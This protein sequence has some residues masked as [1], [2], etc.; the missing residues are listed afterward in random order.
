MKKKQKKNKKKRNHLPFRLNV[1]FFIVFLL[2][3]TLILKLGLTQ[4]V[5]GEDYKRE[6]EKKEEVTVS[7]SVPRGKIYDRNGNVIV[8]NIP[9]N[10][11]TYTGFQGTTADER[12]E[13]ARDL[14]IFIDKDT[15]SVTER[16]KKDFW[17]LTHPEE[18]LEKITKEELNKEDDG[19]L[20]AKDIY[21]LQLDRITEE[22]LATITG[23]ELEVLAIYREFSGYA[24][25]P[26]IVKSR[27]ENEND[28][29]TEEEYA[30]VS[31][32]LAQLPGV[33]TT[34]DWLR[35]YP[36]GDT[37][38]TVLGNITSSKEGLPSEVEDYYVAKEYSRNDRV[39]KS[40][41]EK[42]YE[43]V[44]HGQKEKVKNITD[45]AGNPLDQEVITEGE[46]GKDLVLS[47]DMD[48]QIA[49]EKII[50]EEL[51]NAKSKP[52][53]AF[54]DRAFVV[55]M[56]PSTGEVLSLAGK[57]YTTNEQG[58]VELWDY[59][60]GTFQEAFE[61][62]STVKG[63]TLLTGYETGVVNPG[64]S[65]LDEV[66]YIKGSPQKKSWE[67]MGRIND[68]YALKRSSN[69]YMFKIAISLL[70]GEYQ[71]NQPIPSN[72]EAFDLFRYYFNQFGLGI[73]TGID[74]PGEGTGYVGQDTTSGLLLD[75][76]IGQYDT[77]TPLQLT[78]YVSTIANGGYRIKPQV[79]KD[80]HEPSPDQ[81]GLG[82]VLKE[83]EP[84]V[85]NKIDMKTEYIEQ[86][87]EGFRQVMQ[88]TG[89]TAFGHFGASTYKPAGKTGTAEVYPDGE[90]L[91]YNLTL[92]GYAPY[93]NPEV[94]FAVVVPNADTTG[95]SQINK[96]IGKRILDT[97]FDLKQ[98]R[99][100]GT[101][102]QS[103]EEAT[104]TES[105]VIDTTTE[106]ENEIENENE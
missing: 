78:Q 82:P 66:L 9:L 33:D 24:L 1:L 17:L 70:G 52:G 31:E 91:A 20:E 21:K 25:T 28:E 34:T 64:E 2:F 23:Q 46:N 48:L 27:S 49:V 65:K 53:S 59:A 30:V 36:Y 98:Q 100:S 73:K 56:N 22:E 41:I 7:A 61:M 103:T 62:G 43:E 87:Q 76:A 16:D 74:L 104:N 75:M 97:Y 83:F 10:A 99:A 63:A 37:F 42:Q 81:E 11:I 89:G 77:Y 35:E 3:S 44:L 5:Y 80:I 95:K 57:Q 45:K 92:I 106:A 84:L 6:I 71:R 50:E 90:T 54:L 26:Q 67:V 94:S 14:A 47:I 93:D 79:V 88:E 12:L 51:L 19:E 101:T 38:R 4:I 105:E 85:L 18:A 86:V 58:E 15:E 29:V 69:V 32:H 55:M 8:D 102:Q 68:L 13:V 39:G 60:I 96:D 72:P 40:Y